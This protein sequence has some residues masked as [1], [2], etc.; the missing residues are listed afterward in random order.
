[1]LLGDLFFARLS[2]HLLNIDG[3]RFASAH[4]QLVIAHAQG[5]DT[6]VDAN[7]WREEYEIG[8]FLVDRLDDEFAVVE[9]D[10]PD[11]GPRE[12]DFRS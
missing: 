8:R 10:V 9:R 2:L 6:F 5:E 1:M 7:T 4:V 11:F 12:T 3:V